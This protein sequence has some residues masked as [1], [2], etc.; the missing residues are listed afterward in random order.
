MSSQAKRRVPVGKIANRS[1][2]EEPDRWWSCWKTGGR[3][4][5]DLNQENVSS[6][7]STKYETISWRLAFANFMF[8]TFFTFHT[9]T[10]IIHSSTISIINFLLFYASVA[11]RF[12]VT[13]L[14][15]LI[16]AQAQYIDDIHF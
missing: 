5:K 11:S 4:S 6:H 14:K 8:T 12:V 15:Y 1:S 2:I 7:R 9:H 13:G 3:R 16:E 10:S